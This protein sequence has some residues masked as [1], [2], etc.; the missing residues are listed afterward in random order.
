MDQF[1]E[2]AAFQI[3]GADSYPS[4]CGAFLSFT[5]VT[6]TLGYTIDKSVR[7]SDYEDTSY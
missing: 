7:M 3:K 5:I 2:A 1:G 4:I 6:L